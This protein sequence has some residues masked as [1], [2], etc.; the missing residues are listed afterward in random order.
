MSCDN[1]TPF[2]DPQNIFVFRIRGKHC[3]KYVFQQFWAILGHK[4]VV[5]VANRV[6]MWGHETTRHH[7]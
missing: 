5:I 7:V 2:I 3:Q 6:T 1:L 4:C